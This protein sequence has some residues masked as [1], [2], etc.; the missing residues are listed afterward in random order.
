MDDV[1]VAAVPD[2]EGHGA[3]ARSRQAVAAKPAW[4][5]RVLAFAGAGVGGIAK[6]ACGT[7]LAPCRLAA[8]LPSWLQ[9]LAPS[10]VARPPLMLARPAF[11]GR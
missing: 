1:A 3:L 9:V 10:P 2:R 4:G 11:A 5:A 8:G 6:S 7:R